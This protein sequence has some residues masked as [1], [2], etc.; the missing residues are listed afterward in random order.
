MFER[1]QRWIG[2]MSD[3]RRRQSSNVHV[4]IAVSTRYSYMAFLSSVTHR[5]Q[6]LKTLFRLPPTPHTS[7][8]GGAELKQPAHLPHPAKTDSASGQAYL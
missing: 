1:R 7:S 4:K 3:R 6:M 2:L 8:C 5:L